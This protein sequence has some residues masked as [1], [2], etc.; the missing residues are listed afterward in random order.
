MLNSINT[1]KGVEL[2]EKAK[3][4]IPGGGQ[5]LS[6]RSEMFLPGFWPSYYASANG[7]EISDLDG[8]T[9][10]D[11]SLMGVGTCILGYADPDVNK[12]V[13]EAIDSGS[14]ST[15]NAPEEVELAELLCDIHPWA[16]MVRYARTGGE[17]MAIA[18]RIARAYTGRDKIAFC[19]YHGWSDWYLSANLAHGHNLDS[20]LLL[21]LEPAGVPKGLRDTATPFHYNNIDELKKI[22]AEHKNEIGV[23]VMEPFKLKEPEDDFLVKVRE[24]AD[25]IGAV[26]IFDE[27]SIGWRV[28]V[29][30]V[31]LLYKVNP[32]IAVF[33]KAISNGYPMSAILGTK[34]VMQ[35][36]QNSFISSTYWTEKNGP[37]AALATINKLKK[38]NVPQHLK[39]IGELIKNG[40]QNLA[41]KY[42]LDVKAAGHPSLIV[43]SFNYNE[44]NQAIKTLF[45]QEMLRRGFLAS[46]TIYVSFAH[47]EEHVKKYLSAV[48][49]VF[50]LIREAIKNGTVKKLIQGQIAHAG[51]QRLN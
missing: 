45:T 46:T 29:G 50:A 2:W 19:G 20:H 48:E 14:M 38:F 37:V 12:A 4:I 3:K 47:Q 16:K 36:A 31:H 6:K 34:E 13:K 40:L 39:R 49:E 25:S 17:A 44:D 1:K 15:L 30:G 27:I 9:Y 21:G 51:F 18:V 35:A 22:V 33:S 41:E 5:L 43:L 26:L 11:F 32:D 8:N 10:L 24:I 23:I 42:Q 28:C 7:I